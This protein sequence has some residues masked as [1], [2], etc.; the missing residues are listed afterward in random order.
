LP[1]K[2]IFTEAE[3]ESELDFGKRERGFPDAGCTFSSPKRIGPA[4]WRIKMS[5]NRSEDRAVNQKETAT[6]ERK[7][8]GWLLTRGI[9]KMDLKP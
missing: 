9:F 6:L 4:K 8:K 7:G 1:T 5:C 2:G 3:S